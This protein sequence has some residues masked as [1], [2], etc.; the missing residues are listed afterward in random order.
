[1]VIVE[2]KSSIKNKNA[3]SHIKMQKAGEDRCFHVEAIQQD[4]YN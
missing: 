1:M 2:R 3:K 4:V